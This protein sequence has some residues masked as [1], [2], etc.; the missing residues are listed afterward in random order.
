MIN[1][2]HDYL[3]VPDDGNTYPL[4]PTLGTFPIKNVTD[5]KEKVPNEWLKHG[6]V[7][8]PMHQ[9]EAMWIDFHSCQKYALKLATGKINAITGESWNESI[10]NAGTSK[11]DYLVVPKQP[12]FFFLFFWHFFDYYHF[13]TSFV[14]LT[15]FYIFLI[16]L[17]FSDFF[18]IFL[19]FCIK[20]GLMGLIMEMV[21]LDNS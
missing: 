15:F 7:F 21:W 9:S 16:F 13:L 1:F 2:W 5:Y 12:W 6:G 10:E 3:R 8:I 17:H 11:Q 20:S 4:P 18:D 14:F 19:I